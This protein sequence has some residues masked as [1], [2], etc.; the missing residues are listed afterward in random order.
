[1]RFLSCLKYEFH[2][3]PMYLKSI[4]FFLQMHLNHYPQNPGEGDWVLGVDASQLPEEMLVEKRMIE[5]LERLYFREYAKAWW[6]FLKK[7]KYKEFNNLNVAVQRLKVLGHYEESPLKLLFKEVA[8]QTNLEDKIDSLNQGAGELLG[9]TIQGHTINSQFSV[10]HDLVKVDGGELPKVLRQYEDLSILLE[11]YSEEPPESTA[12]FAAGILENRNSGELYDALNV[13]NQK[14]RMLESVS[15][16]NIFE[17]P[18]ILIWKAVLKKVQEHLNNR[19]FV[20]VVLN[21][22]CIVTLKFVS[23]LKLH[24]SKYLVVDSLVFKAWSKSLNHP[25]GDSK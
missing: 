1:M 14:L 23:E 5:E 7:I 25:H 3:F 20:A 10:I 24:F 2:N 13:I 19:W 18:V 22:N 6:D 15:R 16:R 9:K 17:Q 12:E 4:N 11:T 21:S 8:R